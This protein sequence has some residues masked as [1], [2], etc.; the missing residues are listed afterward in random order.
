MRSTEQ[1]ATVVMNI[2]A[3]GFTNTDIKTD[4]ISILG[5]KK[6]T[7]DA[8]V[9]RGASAWRF[10]ALMQTAVTTGRP[11]IAAYVREM[12]GGGRG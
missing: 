3:H 11:R 7:D 12:R 2:K 6:Q 4:I 8:L 5:S 10:R 9:E 1:K